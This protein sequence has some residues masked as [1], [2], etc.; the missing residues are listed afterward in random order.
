MKCVEPEC[1]LLIQAPCGLI[2][3][4]PFLRKGAHAF[5]CFWGKVVDGEPVAGVAYG[6]RPRKIPPEVE[7]FLGVAGAFRQLVDELF[8]RF[9]STGS[10]GT[11]FMDL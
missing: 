4:R 2:I 10:T 3:N 6:K 9:M 5:A 7:L 1:R 11:L 8:A